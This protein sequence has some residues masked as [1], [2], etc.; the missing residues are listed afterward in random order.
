M[1]N[2]VDEWL[3]GF[4]NLNPDAIRVEEVKKKKKENTIALTDE[5]NAMDFSNKDF[6]KNLSEQQKK[7]IGLWVLMRFMSSSQNQAEHHI[8]MVNDIVNDNFN[9]ISRHPELQWK[10]L[11]LCGTNKKQYHPWIAP[12]KGVK[13]NK[14]EAAILEFYPLL[15]D[16][17][18]ELLISINGQSDWE[19]FF[20]ENGFDDKMIKEIFKK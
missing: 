15:K 5:L 3:D 11:A 16:D 8:I 12:P 4:Y 19:E 1:S 14:L 7:D 10:L 6:Y 20:K 9:V 13:K 17:E 18:L 2:G